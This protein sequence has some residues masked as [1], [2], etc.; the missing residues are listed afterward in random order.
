MV[1]F[2]SATTFNL[3]TGNGVFVG[4]AIAPGI[5]TSAEALTNTAA[6]LPRIELVKPESII[7]KT[8]IENMQSGIIY[9]FTGLVEGIVN[10]MKRESNFDNLKVIATGGMSQLVGSNG[11]IFDKIDRALSLKGLKILYE[12]NV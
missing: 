12:L 11:N 1:D 4:G 10:G 3:I 7:A 9:G 2:G 8:T 6:K 5:K